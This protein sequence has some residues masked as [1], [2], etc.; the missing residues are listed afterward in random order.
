MKVISPAVDQNAQSTSSNSKQSGFNAF[1]DSFRALVFGVIDCHLILR[2]FLK[3]FYQNTL[4]TTS[5]Y[6][7]SDLRRLKQRGKYIC[8]V[9]IDFAAD[10][11]ICL[12]IILIPAFWNHECDPSF[13]MVLPKCRKVSTTSNLLPLEYLVQS[14]VATSRDVYIL[15]TWQHDSHWKHK[16]AAHR[17]RWERE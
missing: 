5:I 13:G 3:H 10:N 1:W 6:V 2:I 8:S 7:W 9:N 17:S 15:Y 11:Y 4:T 16:I 12:T 14:R